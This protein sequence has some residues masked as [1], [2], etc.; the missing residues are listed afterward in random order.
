ML[1][2]DHHKDVTTLLR[3]NKNKRVGKFLKIWHFSF[4]G[5]QERCSKNCHKNGYGI[6]N[7]ES[8][9]SLFYCVANSSPH[10]GDNAAVKREKLP[11]QN[12]NSAHCIG[13]YDLVLIRINTIEA[14]VRSDSTILFK[15]R[16][17]PALSQIAWNDSGFVPSS[18]EQGKSTWWCSKFERGYWD[19]RH[20]Q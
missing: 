20:L 6:D 15:R 19:I 16:S 2:W 10:V 13:C 7:R 12:S 4:N 17:T 14:T 5:N 8:T 1:Q 18:S 11:L 9:F 3:L